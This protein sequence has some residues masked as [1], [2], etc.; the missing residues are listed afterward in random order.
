MNDR[1]LGGEGVQLTDE[2]KPSGRR[3]GLCSCE[4]VSSNSE[5]RNAYSEL[6]CFTV[7]IQEYF[8]RWIPG[9][10][11]DEVSEISHISMHGSKGLGAASRRVLN[12]TSTMTTKKLSARSACC[13]LLKERNITSIVLQ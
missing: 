4:S 13:D 7:R 8:D 3:D 11:L 5:K 2:N 1:Y 6:T 10:S 12:T 9:S